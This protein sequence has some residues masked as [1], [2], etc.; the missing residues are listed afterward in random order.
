MGGAILAPLGAGVGALTGTVAE[1]AATVTGGLQEKAGIPDRG[2]EKEKAE[3]AKQQQVG[4]KD[5][6]SE[7]PLGL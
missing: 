3:L 5:Q 7:N 2:I 1:G 6:S 4:G